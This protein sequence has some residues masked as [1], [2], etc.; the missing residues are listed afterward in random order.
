MPYNDPDA[1]DPMTLTGVEL[2][3]DD[4][5]SVREMAVCFIEEYVRLGLSPDAIL[6]LFD[7]PDFAGP[8]LAVSQL[9]RQT[10]A[11][12][13]TEQFLIRG[14]RGRRVQVDQMPGGHIGL[15]VLE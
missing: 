12:L 8:R 15:P 4:P 10:I 6:Q 3:V 13:I 2:M 5:G 11:E 9:G 7:N 1:T 14:P